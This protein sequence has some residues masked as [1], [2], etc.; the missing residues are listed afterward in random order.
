MLQS[1]KMDRNGTSARSS[2]DW[3]RLLSRILAGS[4]RAPMN[5]MKKP[6]L[7]EDQA[8]I[9]LVSVGTLLTTISCPVLLTR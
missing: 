9:S 5:A 2:L 8:N 1:D 7:S 6:A 4:T 3:A